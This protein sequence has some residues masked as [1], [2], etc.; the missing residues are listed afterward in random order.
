[1]VTGVVELVDSQLSPQENKMIDF[2]LMMKE[3]PHRY[4]V[5]M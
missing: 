2:E 5:G 3:K 1:V 4:Q